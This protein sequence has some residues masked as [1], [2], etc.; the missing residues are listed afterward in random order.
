MIESKLPE[1]PGKMITWTRPMFERFKIAHKKAV[2]EK[3]ESFMFDG[4]EFITN[5]AKYLIEYLGGKFK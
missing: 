2:D 5:Y 3:R 1:K 4:N